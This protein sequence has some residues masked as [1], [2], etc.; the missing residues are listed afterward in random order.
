MKIK[1]KGT[2]IIGIQAHGF[3]GNVLAVYIRF[4]RTP[5]AKSREV[6]PAVFADY[7][8]HGA[9]VGIEFARPGD[10]DIDA[11]QH[12]SKAVKVPQLRAIDVSR[13]PVNIEE[14]E[15]AAMQS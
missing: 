14:P 15:V 2:E 6:M 1:N 11:M 4:T 8:R 7:D 12:V 9:I 13:L 3:G 10:Y 5:V